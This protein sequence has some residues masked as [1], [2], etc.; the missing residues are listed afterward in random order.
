MSDR[1]ALLRAY[2]ESPPPMGVWA[3]RNTAEDKLLIGASPNAPGR[4][5]RE[6]FSLETG[7]HLSVALQA[8]WDRLGADAFVI[9]VLDTLD[10]SEDPDSDPAEELQEL[11]EMWIEKLGVPAERRYRERG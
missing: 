9:E 3:V 8:D 11:L 4:V 6:R 5:N 2:K 1:K 10:P 7:G